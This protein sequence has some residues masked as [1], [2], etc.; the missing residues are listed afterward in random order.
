MDA[1]RLDLLQYLDHD[2]Y[3]G[4]VSMRAA[5][6]LFATLAV[7]GGIASAKSS[8]IETG[9]LYTPRPTVSTEGLLRLAGTV[10]VK[11]SCGKLSSTLEADYCPDGVKPTCDCKATP[12]AAICAKARQ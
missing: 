6:G 3:G 11:C 2:G 8:S 10:K 7:L 9:G 5:I 1:A 12:P 4:R